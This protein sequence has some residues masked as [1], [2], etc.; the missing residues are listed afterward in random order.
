MYLVLSSVVIVVDCVV[1][2]V[3]SFDYSKSLFF[4]VFFSVSFTLF[5]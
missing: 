3:L 1:I 2:V 5:L 4:S